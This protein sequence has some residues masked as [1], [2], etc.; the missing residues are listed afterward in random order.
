MKAMSVMTLM[1]S[2]EKEINSFVEMVKNEVIEGNRNPLE[3]AVLLKS[4]EE[5]C[6]RIKED[7]R[8]KS[9]IRNEAEKYGQKNFED[10]GASIQI[11]DGG[12]WDYSE[13]NDPELERLVKVQEE[14]KDQIKARE[15]VLQNLKKTLCDPETGCE[16]FPA[17]KK[18]QIQVAITLK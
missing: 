12:K 13:C 10:Y 4:L 14:T 11:R 9:A 2:N 15:K 18:S 3:L 7:E 6:K 5:V 8:V 16:I 17:V 1:P